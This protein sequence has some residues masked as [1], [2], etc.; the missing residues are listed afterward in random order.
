MFSFLDKYKRIALDFDGT[1]HG[2]NDNIYYLI[3]YINQNR[4]KVYYIVTFRNYEQSIGILDYLNAIYKQYS[5]DWNKLISK[6]IFAPNDIAYYRTYRM[7]DVQ[8]YNKWKSRVCVQNNLPI[9]VDDEMQSVYDGCVQMGVDF[10]DISFGDYYENNI[11]KNYKVKSVFDIV[12]SV[13]VSM[14]IARYISITLSK[15]LDSTNRSLFD[16]YSF[17][18]SDLNKNKKNITNDEY[19]KL[20]NLNISLIL[21]N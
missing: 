11:S 12:D 6:I 4:N 1:L 5:I 8:M 17:F 18:Y 21:S 13:G 7:D 15:Y 14:H 2:Q 9:L 3:D 10:F 16:I 19:N 20:L